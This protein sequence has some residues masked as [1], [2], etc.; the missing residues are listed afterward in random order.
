MSIVFGSV[1]LETWLE[2]VLPGGP[3]SAGLSRCR[4][5][6]STVTASTV[7]A[8]DIGRLP[9]N[10]ELEPRLDFISFREEL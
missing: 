5:A 6:H 3:T 1:P 7:S 10:S 4:A 9:L 2:E 8:A